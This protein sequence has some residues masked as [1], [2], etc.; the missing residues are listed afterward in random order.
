M[1]NAELVEAFY[2]AF[3]HSQPELLGEILTED[4]KALPPVPGNPGGLAGQQMT[5]GYLHSIFE[6]LSYQPIEII[7]GGDDTTVVRA[8]LSGVHI[9][10]FISVAPTGRK[11]VLDTIEVH[12]IA[13]ERIHSTHHIEDFWGAYLQMTTTG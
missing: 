5:I 6:D 7:E 1:T 4:W 3:H 12:K 8:R 11:I 9:G 13:D 10:E 2:R